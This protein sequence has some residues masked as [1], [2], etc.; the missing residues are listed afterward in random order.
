MCRRE[1]IW[2]T[3]FSVTVTAFAIGRMATIFSMAFDV[4]GSLP[5]FATEG[6]ATADDE[7]AT[8]AAK[9]MIMATKPTAH[10]VP[11]ASAGAS[12]SK[13]RIRFNSFIFFPPLIEVAI[14]RLPCPILA[15]D[16]KDRAYNSRSKHL[17]AI[18]SQ[19]ISRSRRIRLESHQTAGW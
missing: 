2:P 10:Q 19:H 13:Y 7:T 15:T 14:R 9:G 18:S 6:V 5:T 1:W 4:V 8:A 3:Y 11:A 17:A 12:P 16:S